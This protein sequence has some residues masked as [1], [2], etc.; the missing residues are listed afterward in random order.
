MAFA[1]G[2]ALERS[3]GESTEAHAG[4]SLENESA[5]HSESETILGIN[6]ESPILIVAALAISV[7]LVVLAAARSRSRPILL[8]IAVAAI[9]FALFDLLEVA[10]QAK[11]ERY[12]ILV[13]ALIAAG[14]HLAAGALAFALRQ[15]FVGE[16]S[17]R[18][19]TA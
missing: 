19:A 10:H 9:G 2:V 16:R 5:E 7:G 6:P 18:E 12:G 14:A 4:D 8:L 1:L 13:L 15:H 11:T 3:N 17:T